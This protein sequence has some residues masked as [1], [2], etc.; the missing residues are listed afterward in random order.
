M[1]GGARYPMTPSSN[2]AQV[3]LTTSQPK[4]QQLA[5]SSLVLLADLI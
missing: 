4:V 1:Q 3:L 2:S 5:S